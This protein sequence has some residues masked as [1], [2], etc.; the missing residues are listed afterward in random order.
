M[1]RGRLV[2]ER[3]APRIAAEAS[4]R[5]QCQFWPAPGLRSRGLLIVHKVAVGHVML[6]TIDWLVR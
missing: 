1:P 4:K 3:G 2:S 5:A 6:G